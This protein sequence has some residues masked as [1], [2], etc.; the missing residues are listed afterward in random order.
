MN[1]THTAAAADPRSKYSG[2][3]QWSV[4]DANQ[5]G[6]CSSTAVTRLGSLKY[7]RNSSSDLTYIQRDGT[8]CNKLATTDIAPNYA[9]DLQ[10]DPATAWSDNFSRFGAT[11]DPTSLEGFYGYGWQ[12]GKHDNYARIFAVSIDGSAQDGTAWF[13]FGEDI[14]VSDGSI[15]GFFCNWA[16]PGNIKNPMP[17]YVQRQTIKL[18]TALT[19][20]KWQAQVSN[21]RYAPTNSCTYAGSGFWYDRDL[22]QANNE[23]ATDISVS[24]SETDFL[25][26]KGAGDA[27]V[28]DTIKATGMTFAAF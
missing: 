12:A 4:T 10:L 18:N 28:T 7:V 8:Y 26:P 14:S 5:G 1:L 25:Y 6:N 23:S 13:G 16:G 20:G 27:T 9:S 15:K 22:N 19:P 2:V 11:F 24:G 17:Q 21:I 3:M